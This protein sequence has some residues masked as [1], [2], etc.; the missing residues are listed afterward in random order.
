MTVSIKDQGTGQL[1][2]TKTTLY[3]CPASTQAIVKTITLTNTSGSTVKVNLYV[4]KDGTN[5]RRICPKDME[6][7]AGYTYKDNDVHTLDAADLVE[8]DANVASVIDYSI[9]G[10]QEA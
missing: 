3:T 6:L 9:S 10:V 2:T 7:K 1:G 4:Q 8:G 5:S